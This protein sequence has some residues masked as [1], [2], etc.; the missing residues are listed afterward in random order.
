MIKTNTHKEMRVTIALSLPL[1]IG[2]IW[3]FYSC[4]KNRSMVS[5]IDKTCLFNHKDAISPYLEPL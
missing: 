5:N 3:A 4:E 1:T 2:V